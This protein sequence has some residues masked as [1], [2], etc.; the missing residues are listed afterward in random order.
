MGERIPIFPK[1][2]V[3]SIRQTYGYMDLLR[4][5][6]AEPLGGIWGK[7]PREICIPHESMSKGVFYLAGFGSQD[8]GNFLS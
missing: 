2:I 3:I 6:G 5:Q 8:L 1:T 7:A 4:F